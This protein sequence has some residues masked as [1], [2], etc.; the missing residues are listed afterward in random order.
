MS[1]IEKG[2]YPLSKIEEEEMP[3]LKFDLNLPEYVD[4][5]RIGIN[6]KGIYQMC[7]VGGIRTLYVAGQSGETSSYTPTIVGRSEDGTGYAGKTG[8]AKKVPTYSSSYEKATGN[9][10]FQAKWIDAQVQ[11]NLTEMSD[12]IQVVRSTREWS[13]ELNEAL[14]NG[15]SENGQSHLLFGPDSIDKLRF[16][17]AMG[18]G[19][20]V[21][22]D[23]SLPS[24][25]GS[26]VG[27]AIVNAFF[28]VGDNRRY[29][30]EQAWQSGESDPFRWSFFNGIQLDRVAALR[31]LAKVRTLVKELPEKS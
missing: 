25:V 17:V 15:I 24:G 31:G 12:R 9:L 8:I 6:L 23:E 3:N 10:P 21:G 7:R 26:A 27:I 28:N 20:I 11:L 1:R 22:S 5:D 29:W 14:R 2:F 4:K 30:R 19:A 13:G 16:G 18:V